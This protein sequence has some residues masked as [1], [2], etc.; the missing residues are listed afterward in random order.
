MLQKFFENIFDVELYCQMVDLILRLSENTNRE[1]A[2]RE[3]QDH[4]L[5]FSCPEQGVEERYGLH[6]PG[7]VLERLEE[8]MVVKVEQL[9]SLGLALAE[10]RK[11]QNAGMFVGKQKASF[12]KKFR[13]ILAKNDIY[14][15]GILYLCVM[16]RKNQNCIRKCAIVLFRSCRNCF[17]CC[18]CLCMMMSFG[19][20]GNTI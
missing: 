17:L 9:R 14:M 10:T 20:R 11:F 7:E 5:F 1:Q 15:T 13:R 12:W 8:K 18:I 2:Y 3:F 16:T 19:R 6:Y 4:A